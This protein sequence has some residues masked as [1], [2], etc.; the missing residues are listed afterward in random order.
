MR[1]IGLRSTA[2][3]RRLRHLRRRHK[4]PEIY[5]G[6]RSHTGEN[7]Y[8]FRLEIAPPP[9]EDVS[10]VEDKAVW[11][12]LPMARQ[13]ADRIAR[14]LGVGSIEECVYLDFES[15]VPQITAEQFGDMQLFDKL[16]GLAEKLPYLSPQDQM[17][18]KASS[19]EQPPI[20]T[21]R[22]IPTNV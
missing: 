19:A 5:D 17:K 8:A 10:E 13:A 18:F 14:E 20:L 4:P 16:N 11:I 3:D 12:T 15:S 21:I 1:F 9:T 2:I 6:K 7:W 22:D